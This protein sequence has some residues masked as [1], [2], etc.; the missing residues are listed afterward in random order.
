M[1]KQS[2]FSQEW[3]NTVSEKYQYHDRNLIEMVTYWVGY[4][5]SKGSTKLNQITQNCIG[6][7]FTAAHPMQLKY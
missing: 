3:I 6:G 2:S 7:S 1:I 4:L 5:V